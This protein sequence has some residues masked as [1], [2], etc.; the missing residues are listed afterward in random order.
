LPGAI[1]DYVEKL[2]VPYFRAIVAW[3]ECVGVGVTGAE[4]FDI[5]DRH[6]GDSFFGVSLNPGHLIHLDEWV[7]SPIYRGSPQRLCS[8]M[9]LQV[10]VI[11]ATRSAYHTTNMEDG[12][13]LA[14]S[15]LRQAFAEK[16]PDT[17]DRIQ[18]RR[19][20]MVDA[21]GIRLKPEVLPFSNLAGYLPPFWLTPQ[22]AMRV[23]D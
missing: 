15:V 7:S 4:L 5:I 17:W 16:Y 9:A 3:Y 18:R 10:D 13:A 1:A 22:R 12:I 19:R 14:D 6:L 8:G 20:F 23:R 21:L 11:P 2:V